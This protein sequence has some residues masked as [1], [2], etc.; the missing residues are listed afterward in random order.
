MRVLGTIN[1]FATHNDHIYCIGF[2]PW[3]SN[4]FFQVSHG[5]LLANITEFI[6]LVASWPL[7]PF[8]ETWAFTWCVWSETIWAWTIA[9]HTR[10]L[11]WFVRWAISLWSWLS[12]IFSGVFSN[13]KI[14]KHWYSSYLASFSSIK[15]HREYYSLDNFGL[16][17]YRQI[18][19][20][21]YFFSQGLPKW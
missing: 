5:A 19:A 10:T 13:T 17:R 9:P 15:C 8:P 20:F 4:L 1:F 11:G 2:S 14:Q 21:K 7:L 12:M 16:C 6:H 18:T 3:Y